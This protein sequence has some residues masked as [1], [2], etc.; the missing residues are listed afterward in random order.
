MTIPP[1]FRIRIEPQES[2]E[3][4]KMYDFLFKYLMCSW[5]GS[6]GHYAY[7]VSGPWNVPEKQD[8]YIYCET[9]KSHRMERRVISADPDFGSLEWPVVDWKEYEPQ[10]PTP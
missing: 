5:A 9:R 4:E 1:N 7:E 2:V 10:E 8:G 3:L 6:I